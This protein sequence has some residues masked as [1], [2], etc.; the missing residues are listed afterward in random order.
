VDFLGVGFN[1][2]LRTQELP[3]LG[4]RPVDVGTV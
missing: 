4:A 2:D 3:E 1:L